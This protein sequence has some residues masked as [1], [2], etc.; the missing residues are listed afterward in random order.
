MALAYFLPALIALLAVVYWGRRRILGALG[1]FLVIEETGRSCDVMLLLNGN[2]STRAYRAVELYKNRRTPIVLA[3]LAD[4][5]EVR[6]GV[7]PNISEATR[8]LLIRLGV[9]RSDITL[10]ASERWVAGTWD[11]AIL[12]CAHMRARGY[13]SAAIVTDAFHTRRAR[14]TFRNVMRDDSIVFSCVAT[15]YSVNLMDR[16]WRTEYGLVQVFVEYIKFL[17]YRHI[18]RGARHRPPPSEEDLPAAAEARRLVA[19]GRDV[20]WISK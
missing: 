4:T 1:A 12:L 13:R 15:R 2:I 17:H 7:I 9:R 18:H 8:E 19:G 16:W 6:L 10:L 11:E 14:W 3:R 5:E 20:D